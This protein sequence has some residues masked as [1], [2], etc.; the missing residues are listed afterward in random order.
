MTHIKRVIVVILI[1]AMVITSS[2]ATSA[3]KEQ[4]AEHRRIAIERMIRGF[5]D[6]ADSIDISDL[7][8]SPEELG[9]IFAAVTKNSPYLFYVDNTLSYTYRKGGTVVSVI[10]NY[11]YPEKEAMEMVGYC[12]KE[13]SKLASLAMSGESELERLIIIHDLI[14]QK[15]SYDL[16]LQSNNLYS[17]LTTGKGTCQGY[18]WAY[19]A[20]LCDM[21]IECE[22]VASD[23]IVHIWLRVKIGGEWYNSD[24]TWDD[25]PKNEGTGKKSRAHLLFSDAK[26]E[27]DGYTDRY[28]A[29][30]NKCTSDKYDSVDNTR[31]FPFCGS[32]GDIDHDG[33]VTVKDL[34]ILRRQVERG[35]REVR[36]C[37]ICADINADL[38]IDNADIS[39]MREIILGIK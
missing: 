12:K 5:E 27:A 8:L 23:T 32:V 39:A 10:P 4:K 37:L 6:Y 30:D 33:C 31:D 3:L 18:A 2:L 1:I 24:V 35:E 21:G 7:E 17:F 9:E 28:S 15:Y 29:S 16:T 36:S 22:Y 11:L 38:S 25:P 34:L 19:M 13:I 26:A 14:C 20:A